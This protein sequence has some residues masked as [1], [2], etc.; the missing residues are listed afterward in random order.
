MTESL[1]DVMKE[2]KGN[3]DMLISLTMKINSHEDKLIKIEKNQ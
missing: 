1:Q 2:L 3:K